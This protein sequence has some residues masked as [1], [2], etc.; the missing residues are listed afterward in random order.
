MPIPN[1]YYDQVAGWSAKTLEKISP[2]SKFRPLDDK[3]R[4]V[5]VHGGYTAAAGSA[6]YTARNYPQA[7]W[8]RIQMVCEPT[9]H[10]VGSFVLEKDGATYRSN[11]TF[12]T[13]ASIDDWAA[14]NHG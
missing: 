1:R 3:I 13:V 11:N 2:D 5:D 6:I 4:Q 12:N 10:L 9:G 14:A 7:W 8:N